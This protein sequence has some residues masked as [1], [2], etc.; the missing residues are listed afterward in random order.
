MQGHAAKSNVS[1]LK[2]H[3]CV[4]EAGLSECAEEGGGVGHKGQ[5]AQAAAHGDHVKRPH[6]HNPH[7]T[8]QS[9]LKTS[10]A[11]TR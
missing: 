3:L 2:M 11:T 5:H 1:E 7:G 6:L 4:N 9:S 8:S 10:H